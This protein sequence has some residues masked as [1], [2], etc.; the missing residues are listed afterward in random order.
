MTSEF[1]HSS[2]RLEEDLRRR[3]SRCEALAGELSHAVRQLRE[4][5]ADRRLAQLLGRSEELRRSLSEAFDLFSEELP[6]SSREQTAGSPQA[7]A[8]RS[9]VLSLSEGRADTAAGVC[10]VLLDAA[11]S[12]CS[13]ERGFVAL[14]CPETTEAEIAAA[15]DYETRNLSVAEYA[16]SR[17]L[18]RQ[19]LTSGQ[20]VLA[21]N[22][23]G[24]PAHSQHD[25]VRELQLL[26]VLAVP[27]LDGSR[28]VGAVYLEDRRRAGQFGDPELELLTVAGR[29]AVLQLRLAGRFRWA[30]PTSP[31][32]FLQGERVD[33]TIVGRAPALLALKREIRKVAASEATVLIEGETGVGKELVAAA[34]HAQSPRH[35]GP[36]VAINCAAIPEALLESEL[37]GHERGAFTSAV[38]T[39]RG[40]VELARGGTLF[41]DEVGELPYA[42]QPKLLRFLQSSEFRRVGGSGAMQ[43]DVRVVAATSKD[44]RQMIEDGR[45]QDA[46]FYRLHVIPLRVPP[47]RERATDIPLLAAHFAER[48]GRAYG[49]SVELM[50]E[51]LERLARYAFPGNV[52]ELQ[53]LVHRLVVRCEDDRVHVEDLP[54]DVAQGG[55]HR[56]PLVAPA[57]GALLEGTPRDMADLRARRQAVRRLL[58]EQERALVDRVAAECGGNTT[59][60]ARRLGLH[61]GTLHSIRARGRS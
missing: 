35:E 2:S 33:E 34:L 40:Q 47:L 50:P 27:L 52:R 57:A 29:I 42:L 54:A 17:S 12:A 49:R 9:M 58:A 59:E 3:R 38:Q 1:E 32:V 37:F 26:S 31:A 4:E 41:L 30:A 23:A 46:L 56:V 6:P 8:L 14:C 11:I 60:A 51:V 21:A 61:R 55:V 43:A 22:A 39:R 13:A 18:L 28:V 48:F 10:A 36:F 45:F 19:V 25:S 5:S 53:S 16:F 15:R 24:D 44:L 7:A 20:P